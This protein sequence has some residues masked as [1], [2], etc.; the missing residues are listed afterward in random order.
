MQF[1]GYFITSRPHNFIP[2]VL[3]MTYGIS[4]YPFMGNKFIKHIFTFPTTFEVIIICTNS[5][6]DLVH[7]ID[8]KKKG[9]T[10]M[11]CPLI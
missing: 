3:I 11:P 9:I 2:E 5:C 8:F 4:A 1:Y 7:I 6:N 10:K